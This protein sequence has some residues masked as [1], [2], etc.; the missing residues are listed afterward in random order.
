LLAGERE[1]L[2]YSSS[3][4]E[5][6]EHLERC[7]ECMRFLDRQQRLAEGIK[8]IAEETSGPVLSQKTER[9]LATAFERSI[10]RGRP[11]QRGSR[12][13]VVFTF[14]SA[15]GLVLVVLSGV[16]RVARPRAPGETA[17]YAESEQFVMVPYVVPLA[18]YERTEVLR[19]KVSLSALQALGFQVHTPETGGSVAADVLCGQDGRVVA[20]AVLP[21]D[22]AKSNEKVEE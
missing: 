21:D 15:L 1:W 2:A 18:P 22:L 8:R 17:R 4:K 3:E 6:G 7:A 16:H 12:L 11:G 19:M 5:L 10:S 9:A 14:A 20:I 13:R